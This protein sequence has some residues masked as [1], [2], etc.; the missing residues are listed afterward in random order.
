M[1]FKTVAENIIKPLLD[2]KKWVLLITVGL[3]G[4]GYTAYDFI[5][6]EHVPPVVAEE[7]VKPTQDVK[8]IC[9]DLIRKHVT[10]IH[11][12]D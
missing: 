2:N 12:E 3:T 11:L 4:W 1:K 6:Q 5:E 10:N 8:T 7:G 9:A